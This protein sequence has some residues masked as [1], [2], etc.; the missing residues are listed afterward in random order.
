MVS[1]SAVSSMPKRFEKP[2]PIFPMAAMEVIVSSILSIATLDFV[3]SFI[4]LTNTDK[5]L[6][7]SLYA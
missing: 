4:S 2:S 5:A 3:A 7:K 6:C 1:P